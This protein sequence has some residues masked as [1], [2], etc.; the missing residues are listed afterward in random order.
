MP[1]Q[2][3]EFPS[4]GSTAQGYLSRPAS[5]SGPGVIVIQE[6]WGL[7]DH[8]KRW[9]IDSRQRGSSPWLPTFI[10]GSRPTAPMM[11]VV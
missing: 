5:G 10:T 2:I 11:P 8:I 6:W 4:N 3:V 7:V 1:G 9:P